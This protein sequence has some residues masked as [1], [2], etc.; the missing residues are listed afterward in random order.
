MYSLKLADSPV[1]RVIMDVANERVRQDEKWGPSEARPV[2]RLAVLVEEVGE[3]ADAMLSRDRNN[4]RTE[5]IQVAAV[6]L[7]MV[8]GIDRGDVPYG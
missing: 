3:V 2:P 8:E 6:A 4:I 7:A 5:L 1:L